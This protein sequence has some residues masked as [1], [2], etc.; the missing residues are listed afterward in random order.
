[1]GNGRDPRLGRRTSDRLPARNPPTPTESFQVYLLGQALSFALLKLGFEPLHATAVVVDG[2]A[3]ALLGESGSG[4]STLAAAFVDAGFQMLTDDVLMV[5]ECRGEAMAYPGPARL[6]LFPKVAGPV[7]QRSRRCRPNERPDA[8]ARG[9]S[10]S[11]ARMQQARADRCDLRGRAAPRRAWAS[12]RADRGHDGA[13]CG[14]RAGQGDVQSALRESR[15]PRPSVLG[16]GQ[17][18]GAG[19]CQQAVVSEA[20]I[21]PS[22]SRE[23]RAR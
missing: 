9:A 6:K 16:L 20:P 22:R 10:C 7:R 15:A 11:A 23:R 14:A 1:M 21:A 8:E 12:G 2:R 13:G 4:K 5:H 17:S 3:V 18:C 19:A